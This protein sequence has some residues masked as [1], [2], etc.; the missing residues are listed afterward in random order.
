MAKLPSKR[1]DQLTNR[2]KWINLRQALVEGV[3]SEFLGGEYDKI[4]ADERVQ[5]LTLHDC[6][7]RLKTI[8]VV[9]D[10]VDDNVMH[11]VYLGTF[12]A[13]VTLPWL[14]ESRPRYEYEFVD[15]KIS[16]VH[17][18]RYDGLSSVRY[19]LDSGPG[20]FCF[21][22][23]RN[24]FVWELIHHGELFALLRITLECLWKVNL[25]DIPFVISEY[26]KILPDSTI[27]PFQKMPSPFVA[28]LPRNP[29]TDIGP[30]DA[31]I[32]FQG[33]SI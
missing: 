13:T 25:R 32:D 33:F 21:G 1:K 2:K 11:K 9:L 4:I 14:V 27:E 30:E 31:H 24:M 8:P 3:D 7:V 16:C 6:G 26:R 23:G 22:T 10:L 17:S 29:Q 20:K 12:A 5:V 18:G 19:P 28:D 15:F